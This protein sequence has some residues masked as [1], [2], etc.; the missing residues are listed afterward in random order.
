MLSKDLQRR[1][2][3]AA[4]L[5]PSGDNCQPWRFRWSGSTLEIIFLKERAEAF[6]DVHHT[7]SWI[8]LGTTAENI[9]VAAAH[10]GLEAVC[11]FS[12]AASPDLT[13][14]FKPA[15]RSTDT[16][17][18]ALAR[19]CSNRRSYAR[20]PLTAVERQ[21]LLSVAN[22]SQAQ[23]HWLEGRKLVSDVARACA[24]FDPLLFSHDQ[25]H[26]Y[27]Y[28]WTRW[29]NDARDGLPVGSLELNAIDAMGFRNL[30]SWRMARLATALGL[31]RLLGF[32]AA[33]VYRNSAAFGCI[34]AAGAAG[35]DFF[36]AGRVF[37][38]LWTAAAGLNLSLQPVTGFVFMA[39]RLRL[40]Q[41]EGL[42]NAQ[43]R[44]I[45]RFRE[46]MRG[47][48]PAFEQRFPAMMFRIGHAP[49]PSVRARRLPLEELLVK[50]ESH[51]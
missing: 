36:E 2:L 17:Y 48:C 10:D 24:Q 51:A 18:A 1:I 6:I 29:N 38:R 45:E 25:M 27:L 16:M 50:G 12:S 39:L 26:R 15:P 47:V 44:G 46:Y 22:G 9:A 35:R 5:A 28:Q 40:A 34:T 19:R 30:A 14:R 13:I 41:G 32:R 31:T 23:L 42:S 33:R 49:P 37:G 21:T 3:E 20:T 43:R 4:A 8:A 11:Q 7:A